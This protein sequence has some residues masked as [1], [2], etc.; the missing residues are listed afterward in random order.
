M[1]A[2]SYARGV[3]HWDALCPLHQLNP[4]T[5]IVST[6]TEI[7]HEATIGTA[8]A[9]EA[10]EEVEAEEDHA[11]EG[12]EEEEE[13]GVRR[14]LQDTPTPRRNIQ[15]NNNKLQKSTI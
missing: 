7:D 6:A 5:H 12:M 14:Y 10:G 11:E 1:P 13:V 2:I 4:A 15:Q 8:V 9:M 3:Y